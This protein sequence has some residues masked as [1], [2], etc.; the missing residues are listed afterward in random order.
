MNLV[1]DTKHR[2]PCLNLRESFKGEFKFGWDEAYHAERPEFRAYEAAWLTIIPGKF[3]KVFP[4]G[5]RRLAAYCTAGV[6]KRV[7]LAELGVIKQGG[8]EA[9][10]RHSFSD[11]IVVFEPE[12]LEAVAEVLKL[13]RPR[14]ALNDKQRAVLAAGRAAPFVGRKTPLENGE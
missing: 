12:Q 10:D 9:I 1:Y 5:G 13:R 2:T 7:Q 11:V 4:W 8:A 14:K 3:G 6:A